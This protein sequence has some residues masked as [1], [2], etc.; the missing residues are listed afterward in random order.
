MSTKS[1]KKGDA[2]VEEEELL[3]ETTND[4]SSS[5]TKKSKKSKKNKK[6]KRDAPEDEDFSDADSVDQDPGTKVSS[7]RTKAEN[8]KKRSDR[9]RMQDDDV[10]TKVYDDDMLENEEEVEKKTTKKK[11]KS[12]K[13]KR[14][15]VTY[16]D[17]VLEREERR[18]RRRNGDTKNDDD[19]EEEKGEAWSNGR[20]SKSRRGGKRRSDDDDDQVLDDDDDWSPNDD[21]DEYDE[22][23][24]DDAAGEFGSSSQRR[25]GGKRRRGG[26]DGSGSSRDGRDDHQDD[27]R[28]TDA[29]VLVP[30]ETPRDDSPEMRLLNRFRVNLRQIGAHSDKKGFISALHNHF[31]GVGRGKNNQIAQNEFSDRLKDILRDTEIN[32]YDVKRLMEILDSDNNGFIDWDEFVS[33]LS[34]PSKE[35]RKLVISLRKRMLREAGSHGKSDNFKELF[36]RLLDKTDRKKG[37]ITLPKL[38]EYFQA[39]LQVRLTPGETAELFRQI[40]STNVGII[41]QAALSSFLK[42]NTHDLLAGGEFDDSYPIVDVAVSASKTDEQNLRHLGYHKINENLNEGSFARPAVFVWWRSSSADDYDTE[43]AFM[44][45][46]V[47]DII[48]SSK[49]RDSMLTAEGFTCIDK[50]VS[51]GKILPG[52]HAYIWIRKD[53]KDPAP[54]LNIA[55]T[56]GKAKR[57]TDKVHFPPFH[58]FKLTEPEHNLNKSTMFGKD[59]F[60]WYRKKTFGVE[61]KKS[62][63]WYCQTWF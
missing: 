50:S 30:G 41:T 4:S 61:K 56:T 35:M 13:T 54:V 16:A 17:D 21:D 15:G 3:E 27:L 10:D 57:A 20:R 22:Y 5:K 47:T 39:T 31:V 58:G 42:K 33:F 36:N 1:S 46:R 52:G 34:F 14:K 7:K 19:D 2:R 32:S 48:V 6:S 9:A 62:Q 40:D 12:N 44:K 59:V 26:R 49:N 55:V 18:D 51:S 45:D 29:D 43:I 24:D 8:K 60:M 63:S 38:R 37:G 25:R 53:S 11:K 28:V 23:D